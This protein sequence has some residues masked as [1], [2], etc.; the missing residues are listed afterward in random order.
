MIAFFHNGK[1][2]LLFSRDT[3][4]Q[5][6]FSTSAS[7][8]EPARSFIKKKLGADECSVIY[9]PSGIIPFY[10]FSMLRKRSDF[11]LWKWEFFLLNLVA[12]MC[13]VFEDPIH[14]YF[15]FR[16][17]YMKYFFNLHHISASANVRTIDLIFAKMKFLD[18]RLLVYVF[19]SSVY[20]DKS[21]R[22]YGFTSKIYQVQP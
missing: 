5:S 18:R 7:G 8:C 16:Q 10:G 11:F 3:S 14:L 12:P 2:L 13:C 21:H 22:K 15:I 4:V 17:F 1:V 6:C 9:P 19:C 20:Y